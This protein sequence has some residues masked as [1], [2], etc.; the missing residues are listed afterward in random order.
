[1]ESDRFEWDDAKA[2][3]N[4][5]KHR[6]GFAEAATVFEDPFVVIEP[7]PAHSMDEVRATATGFP[8]RS[9][10]L[11]VVYAERR[12]RIR[13]IGA[14]RATSEERRKYESQFE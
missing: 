14:R 3:T 8:T 7:D 11:L 2:D 13:L 12:D 4:L 6:I 5:R 10:V 1:L 9:R